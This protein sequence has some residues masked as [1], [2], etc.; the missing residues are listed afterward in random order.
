MTRKRT[1]TQQ[2]QIAPSSE[3]NDGL[4]LGQTDLVDLEVDLNYIRSVIRQ[5]K[6]TPKYDDIVDF[7][8]NLDAI[9]D[10]IDDIYQQLGNVSFH[11]A[12]LT[13]NSTSE[14]PPVA[15]SSDRIATTEYVTNVL[16]NLSAED[17][18]Y[19]HSQGVAEDVW[20]ISHNLNKKPAVAIEDSSHKLVEA[21]VKHLDDNTLEILFSGA[22]S[23]KAYLN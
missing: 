15:D 20:V 4:P 13:G 19:V 17:K 22:T 23:G 16:N 7:N 2:R 8:K 1:S 10:A 9:G 21:S 12:V 18:Y 11:D 14:T 3:V 6:G 5:L